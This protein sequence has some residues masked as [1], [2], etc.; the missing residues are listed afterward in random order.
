[1]TRI[2]AVTRKRS[3]STT[4]KSARR[5]GFIIVVMVCLLLAGMLV[6]SLLKLALLQAGQLGHEQT[7]L[8]TAWLADSAL[9]R[10]AS[11]LARDDS[12]EGETWKISAAQ[13][14]GLDGA[15]VVIRVDRGEAGQ[16]R[17]VVEATYPAEGPPRARMTRQATLTVAKER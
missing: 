9:K 7:R 3:V 6:A 10:A 17:V 13:L 4:H 16:P 14:R 2:D 5:G 11:R 15:V 8:Q 1:M 12:Y